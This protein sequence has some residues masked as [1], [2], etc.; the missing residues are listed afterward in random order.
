MLDEVWGDRIA[1]GMVGTKVKVRVEHR[2]EVAQSEFGERGD[3]LWDMERL[4]PLLKLR[5]E[6]KT[7]GTTAAGRKGNAEWDS[8]RDQVICCPCRNEEIGR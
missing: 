7:Y 6:R 1:V 3:C 5:I 4:G 8:S 2:L